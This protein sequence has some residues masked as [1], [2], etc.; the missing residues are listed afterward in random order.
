V[1]QFEPIPKCATKGSQPFEVAAGD[2]L[3]GLDL[4]SQDAT[5][6]AELQRGRRRRLHHRRLHPRHR[7]VATLNLRRLLALGLTIENGTWSLA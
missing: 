4:K 2:P 6:G 5:V 3:I 1:A 7:F